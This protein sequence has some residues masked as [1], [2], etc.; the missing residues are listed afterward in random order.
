[1]RAMR[2]FY[3][4][5]SAELGG[6]AVTVLISDPSAMTRIYTESGDEII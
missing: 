6:I 4:N 2:D 5:I 1:M 3:S